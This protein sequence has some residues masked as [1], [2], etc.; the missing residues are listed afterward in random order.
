[1]IYLTYKIDRFPYNHFIRKRITGHSD[2]CKFSAGYSQ[3]TFVAL[4][5]KGNDLMRLL[6]PSPRKR[7]SARQLSTAAENFAAAQFAMSGFDVLEQGARTRCLYDLGVAN[8]GGMLKVTVQGSFRG[9]W[10]F[11][12]QFLDP[13]VPA[14]SAQYHKAIDRWRR[15]QGADTVYCLVQFESADLAA[16]PR[17][18]L[19]EAAEIAGRLHAGVDM[20]GDTALYEQFEVEDGS[21]CHT[22]EMLPPQWRFSPARIAELMGSRHPTAALDFRFSEAAACTASQPAAC[23]Q[24]LPMVN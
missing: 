7:L 9:F 17:L 6:T 14:N 23:T 1:M 5:P 19:A 8:A 20:L 12:D 10:N 11:V 15:R 22:V 4:L 24:S 3:L 21:G 2:D 13:A 18:Y 16:M